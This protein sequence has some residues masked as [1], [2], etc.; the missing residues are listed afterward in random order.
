MH[1]CTC[2]AVHKR[3]RPPIPADCPAG[4]AELM[5]SCW[6]NDAPQRPSFKDVLTSLQAQY[7]ELRAGKAKVGS[8]A[9]AGAAI[10]P[11]PGP[12]AAAQ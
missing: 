3:E 5:Q 8:A 1:V 6:Q 12:A 11:V 2:A 7:S 9:A 10:A 4:Y